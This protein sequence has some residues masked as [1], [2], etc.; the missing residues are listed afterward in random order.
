MEQ[1]RLQRILKNLYAM[2]APGAP[3]HAPLCLMSIVAECICAHELLSFQALLY[4]VVL[5]A[6]TSGINFGANYE[7]IESFAG[8]A[9]IHR[10]PRKLGLK[11]RAIDIVYWEVAA[12]ER[13]RRGKNVGK[14]NPCDLLEPAGFLLLGPFCWQCIHGVDFHCSFCFALSSG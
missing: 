12:K 6:H 13:K 2:R 8:H 14:T 7:V 3:Q 11:S 5:L 10:T 4:L 9:V 1:E